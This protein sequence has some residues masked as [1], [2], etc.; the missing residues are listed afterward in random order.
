MNSTDYSPEEQKDIEER[1]AK[2]RKALEEL[3]LRPSCT[4]QMFN[5]GDDVFAPKVIPFL[6][7]T[8]YAP[9]LSPIQI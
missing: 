4:V 1:V 8:K 2:A 5:I 7:D 3:E 9:T 6:Q